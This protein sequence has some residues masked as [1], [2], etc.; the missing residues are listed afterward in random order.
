MTI[1]LAAIDR[2]TADFQVEGRWFI[3]IADRLI[4]YKISMKKGLNIS[5]STHRLN[6]KLDRLL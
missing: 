1:F 3:H 2:T 4:Y 6:C 5:G